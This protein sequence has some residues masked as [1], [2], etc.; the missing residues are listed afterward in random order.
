MQEHEVVIGQQTVHQGIRRREVHPI[1]VAKRRAQPTRSIDGYQS[2]RHSK[3]RQTEH[4]HP[5]G[6][7]P[8]L[9]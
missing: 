3:A 7:K 1:V 4:E 5:L 8:E 6:C 2:Y 9:C